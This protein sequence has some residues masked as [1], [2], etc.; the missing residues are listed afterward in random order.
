MYKAGNLSHVHGAM[1]FDRLS[2]IHQAVGVPSPP[3]LIPA[4]PK[5]EPCMEDAP[6]SRAG[7]R[8][9][10]TLEHYTPTG[11][12]DSARRLGLDMRFDGL[13]NVHM[14]YVPSENVTLY[15]HPAE[16]LDQVYRQGPYWT[17]KTL[18]KIARALERLPL[19]GFG[20]TGSLAT[21]T[22]NP[23]YSD[24]DIVVFE[25]LDPYT[26]LET[27]EKLGRPELDTIEYRGPLQGSYRVGWR[28]RL[29]EGR[30]VTFVAAPL[31]PGSTCK[32]LST[33]WAIDT[34]TLTR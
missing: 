7:L 18:H 24:I 25:A 34:P 23:A 30:R 16:A 29:V 33:Y 26:L 10:R 32:P 17:L 5:Y 13:Y 9:C 15:I 31:E 4:I 19:R 27:L 22:S 21:Q 8:F 20:L 2:R 11:V 3:G 14:P 28:R 1:I 12:E 6:W